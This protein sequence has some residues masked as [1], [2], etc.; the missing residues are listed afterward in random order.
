MVRMTIH[1]NVTSISKKSQY[2]QFNLT[3]NYFD[4]SIAYFGN[5]TAKCFDGFII[6]VGNYI[7]IN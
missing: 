4:G 3:T 7:F 1:T 5:F 6:Y 2:R